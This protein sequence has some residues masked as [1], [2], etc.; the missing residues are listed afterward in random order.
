MSKVYCSAVVPAPVQEVWALVRDFGS[1]AQWHP[2][3][4]DSRI[5]GSQSGDGRLC[6]DVPPPGRRPSA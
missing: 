3:V 4:A 1:F 2:M 5:E 6:A